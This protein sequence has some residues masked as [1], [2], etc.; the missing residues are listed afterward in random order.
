[1][2]NT[3]V[4][5]SWHN[6]YCLSHE[7]SLVT[8]C[9]PARQCSCTLSTQ[10]NLPSGM[11]DT[12]FHVARPVAPTIQIWN[13][14]T[15]TFG[16]KCNSICTRCK[17]MTLTNWSSVHSMSGVACSKAW[18]MSQLVSGANVSVCVFVPKE[19]IL[20]IWL[21]SMYMLTFSFWIVWM[22]GVKRRHCCFI[23]LITSQFCYF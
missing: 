7:T 19:G 22:L 14:L 10:N 5:C 21:N 17:F 4:A 12:C 2:A 3:I 23:V 6:S 16:E 13:R 20:R 9:L 1:M 8:F 11:A 15:T 18:L